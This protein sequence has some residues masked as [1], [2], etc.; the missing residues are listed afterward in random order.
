ME[1]AQL[2]GEM[3]FSMRVW[4]AGLRIPLSLMTVL[5]AGVCR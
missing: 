2:L 3:Y 1:A 4:L 5:C